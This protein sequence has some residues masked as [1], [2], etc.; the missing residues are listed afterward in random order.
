MGQGPTKSMTNRMFLF[1]ISVIIL[2][3]MLVGVLFK[4]QMI[5]G[6]ELQSGALGQQT[7]DITI[8]ASRGT[9]FDCNY[10]ALAESAS[11][12]KIILSPITVTEEADRTLIAN[13]LPSILGIEK[14]EVEE[15]LKEES[16]YVVLARRVEQ[17]VA[18]KVNEFISANGFELHISVLDD[19]KRYYPLGDFA[20][21]VIGF[22][23]A[24]NQGLA[25]IEAQ[26]EDYLSGEEGRVIA[27]KNANG[28][29]MSV[30]YEKY[31]EPTDGYDLVLTLDE[32]I[33]HYLEKRLKTAYVDHKITGYAAGIVMDVK[34]GG[35]LG[36]AQIPGFDLNDPFTLVDANSVKE[37]EELS[38]EEYDAAYVEALNR[39]WRN[40]NVSDQYEPGSTFKS[41]VT[42]VVVEEGLANDSTSF[43]CPGYTD[44]YGTIIHCD[45]VLGHG[46]QT[47]QDAFSNSCNPAFMEMGGLIGKHMYKRYFS[48]FGL[49][50][51]TGIDLPGESTGI[52]FSD[53]A[54]GPVEFACAAFGQGFKVT[55]IQLITAVSSIAN[56]G[57]MMQPYLVSKIVDDEG[58]VVKSIEPTV[59]NQPI[60]HQTANKVVSMMEE[61][62]A[63]GGGT[64][65]YIK[66]Y[67]I[68]GKS[69]TSEKLG[70]YKE[71]SD[72]YES[73]ASFVAYAPADDPQVAVLI[74]LD[75]PQTYP[76]YGGVIAAPIAGNLLKDI[77]D[78]YDYTPQYSSDD[79]SETV[80]VPSLVDMDSDSAR[81]HLGDMNLNSKV[82]G[83]GG[84]VEQQVPAQGQTIPEGGTV[85]LYT[86]GSEP[87]SEV[88][89]PDLI[90]LTASEANYELINAGLNI[91]IE[92]S[93][94]EGSGV[95]AIWQ[96][97]EQGTKVTPG[98][99]ITVEFRAKETVAD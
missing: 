5:E 12:Y 76:P 58:N 42:S 95:T 14:S 25:G 92:G 62:V 41:L 91:R 71:D 86:N 98:T 84:K 73:I 94:V 19:P 77:L 15:A 46:M 87:E 52:F 56:D 26:Y 79:V 51:A 38:G 97:V 53:D 33:Q 39:Q 20:S 55:P 89:V 43:Y 64:N 57:K 34:T 82:I 80:T 81:M 36:M 37:L 78:Y 10:K 23:G 32:T 68:C 74:V 96:S 31:I 63:T 1:F 67:R 35:I 99:V 22:V 13:N 18:D 6:E 61:V 4:L 47:F 93:D 88:S 72:I 29:D 17:D 7:S 9:I 21:Q 90:G 30:E 70:E 83:G 60:S 45:Y 49:D 2:F 54:L 59:T 28:A 50:S 69:G 27:I 85:I 75:E 3:V 24:D 16:Y 8:S 11:A 44:V 66:G 40:V 65:A 48:G